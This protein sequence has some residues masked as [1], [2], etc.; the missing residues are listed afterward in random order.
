MLLL[1]VRKASGSSS[2]NEAS[3]RGPRTAGGLRRKRARA[4]GGGKNQEVKDR[5]ADAKSEGRQVREEPLR[6]WLI[7]VALYSDCGAK[8]QSAEGSKA[9]R[10][11]GPLGGMKSRGSGLAS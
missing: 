2:Y 6:S 4:E 1:K 3:D 10:L 5:D 7:E 8:T 9:I 11:T